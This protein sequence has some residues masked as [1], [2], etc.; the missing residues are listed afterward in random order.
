MLKLSIGQFSERF[1]PAGAFAPETPSVAW[2]VSGDHESV[3]GWHQVT[4]MVVFLVFM[5][6]M[7]L[8]ESVESQAGT[9]SL[10]EHECHEQ[11]SDE[12]AAGGDG[13]G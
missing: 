6:C 9:F 2:G 5:G 3:W 13:R 7:S 4:L 11:D 12:N 8:A 10:K 1:G